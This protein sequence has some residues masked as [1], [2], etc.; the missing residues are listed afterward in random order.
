MRRTVA[1]GGRQVG[2]AS[3]VEET[4]LRVGQH[5]DRAFL[6]SYEPFDLSMRLVAS[7]TGAVVLTHADMADLPLG[8]G[9]TQQPYLCAS[10]ASPMGHDYLVG[11]SPTRA[12]VGW[13]GSWQAVRLGN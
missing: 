7:R 3:E 13:P 2:N 11:A 8:F 12:M 5:L 9:T 10:G 1:A 6:T 4:P